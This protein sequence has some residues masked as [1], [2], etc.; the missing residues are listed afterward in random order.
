MKL[1]YQQGGTFV[2]PFAV[3]QPFV[4]PSAEEQVTQK[5]T[6]SKD[7]N[8]SDMERIYKLLENLDGLPGDIN[9]VSSQIGTLLENID[10]KLNSPDTG[11]FG[12]T[13]SIVSEYMQILNLTRTLKFQK[14]Q[15]TKAQDTAIKNGSIHEA[16]I[17]KY[18]RVMVQSK[19]GFDWITPEEYHENPQNYHIITNSELLDYRQQGLGGL[20]FNSESLAT[21]AEGMGINEVTKMIQDSIQEL[22]KESTKSQTYLG[23][24]QGQLIKGLEDLQKAKSSSG[25]YNATTQDLYELNELNE[26]EANNALLALNY[27]YNSLPQSAIALLKM[28][29]DGTSKGVQK[30]IESLVFSKVDTKVEQL[31]ELK[32][33]PTKTSQSKSEKGEGDYKDS[34][35]LQLVKNTGGTESTLNIDPGTGIKMSISGRLHSA[36]LTPNGDVITESTLEQMLAKSVIQNLVTNTKNITFG[37]QK[38]TPQQLPF[39]TYNNSGIVRTIL[40]VKS[41]GSVNIQLVEK[42]QQAEKELELTKKTPEDYKRIYTKYKLND[43]L[44]ANGIPNMNKFAPFLVTEGYSTE[45]NGL[46][47]S[48]FIYEVENPTDLEVKMLERALSTEDSPVSIDTFNWINPAD[49]FGWHDNIYKAAIY[50]PISPNVLNATVGSDTSIDYNEALKQDQKYINFEKRK[51][52]NADV[53]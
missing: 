39:I 31:L 32:G 18:G 13:N 40:P 50:I 2:P 17:D 6:S 33:G 53:L 36:I 25:N 11:L 46:K 47:K 28:K 20:A 35:L 27:I 22:G 5:K 3:Y 12:E 42:Y 23:V 37:D 38:I 30:M 4:L 8:K 21:V 43:L 48:N 49:W 34:F 26:T 7:E 29:S 9:A 19:E 45:S 41:D 16:A 44:D 14:D 15:Y 1:K 51:Q 24:P 10:Y 52:Y